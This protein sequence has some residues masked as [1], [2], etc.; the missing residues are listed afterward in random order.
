[1]PTWRECIDRQWEGNMEWSFVDRKKCEAFSLERFS[2]LF[3]QY[4]KVKIQNTAQIEK[5]VRT[6]VKWLHLELSIKTVWY[7]NQLNVAKPNVVWLSV[8]W[9]SVFAIINSN[10]IWNGEM[11]RKEFGN[12]NVIKIETRLRYLTEES[13]EG[14][15]NYIR[16]VDIP[17]RIR[18][19]HPQKS[20]VKRYRYSNLFGENFWSKSKF[21]IIIGK[22]VTVERNFPFSYLRTEPVVLPIS[23]A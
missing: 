11:H 9:L 12:K 13:H 19:R 6:L 17:K 15:E 2:E 1:M 21:L 16:L 4:V 10:V 14:Y 3:S 5:A 23:S 18:I 8:V 7:M 22:I 20:N